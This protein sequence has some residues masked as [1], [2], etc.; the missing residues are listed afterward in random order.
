[1]TAAALQRQAYA[2]RQLELL[3]IRA[4]ELADQVAAGSLAFLDG[5]DLAYSA[6]VW[7]DLPRAIERAGLVEGITTGDDVVQSVLAA[8]FANAQRWPT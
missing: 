5:V 7:A 2:Q 6:A 1:M 4:C 3:A 8:A